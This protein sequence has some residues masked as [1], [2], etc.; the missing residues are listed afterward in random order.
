MY[1]SLVSFGDDMTYEPDLHDGRLLSIALLADKAVELG[2]STVTGETVL[3]RINGLERFR[4]DNFL[5]GNIILDVLGKTGEQI[6][7]KALAK[8]MLEPESADSVKRMHEQARR[9]GWTLFE[10]HSSYGCDLSAL[11]SGSIQVNAQ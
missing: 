3:I 1:D 5:E 11:A 2:C 4:V 9:L 10:I 6:D 8:A 7:L